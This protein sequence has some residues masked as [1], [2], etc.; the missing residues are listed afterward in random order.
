MFPLLSPPQPSKSS[1]QDS[2]PLS[3]GM[4]ILPAKNSKSEGC[5]A[6]SA[7][8]VQPH[9]ATTQTSSLHG[10]TPEE[11]QILRK[12]FLESKQGLESK[13]ELNIPTFRE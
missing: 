12:P 6:L 11:L 2:V 9:K 3:V 13:P 10:S 4:V 7:L 5:P 1:S 8:Q